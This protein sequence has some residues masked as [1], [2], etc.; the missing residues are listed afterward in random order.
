[1]DMQGTNESSTRRAWVKPD[2]VFYKTKLCMFWESNRCSR[3]ANCKY[4]HGEE[5]LQ[6]APNLEKT[7]MC[8]QLENYGYCDNVDCKFAHSVDELRV[9]DRFHKTAMCHFQRQGTC[10]QGDKCRYAHNEDELRQILAQSQEWQVNNDEI[11]PM[12]DERY[13][14]IKKNSGDSLEVFQVPMI[15]NKYQDRAVM[16]PWIEETCSVPQVPVTMFPMHAA[17]PMSCHMAPVADTCA[18]MQEMNSLTTAYLP[19]G[20]M[21]NQDTD[22]GF[23]C[24][25]GVVNNEADANFCKECGAK[26]PTN[27]MPMQFAITFMPCIQA[28]PGMIPVQG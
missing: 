26:R 16:E 24:K 9:T 23:V 1:M 13:S 21:Q 14:P 28:M 15:D 4:A 20:S 6:N 10:K 11:R 12:T 17:A 27:E 22:Q 18:S 19:F 7:A 3:G 25:C 5:E 2:D 8:N